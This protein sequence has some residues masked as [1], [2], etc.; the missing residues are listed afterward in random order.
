[1]PQ[2]KDAV[3]RLRTSNKQRSRNRAY[4]TR[5][6]N[7]IRDLRAEPSAPAAPEQ[8]RQA[9]S[10]LDRAARHGVIHSNTAARHKRRLTL[11][12]SEASSA[13]VG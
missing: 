12:V 13:Q 1:M 3:K 5:V 7:A 11:L 8:L 4:L 10:L 6:R 9:A 2:H